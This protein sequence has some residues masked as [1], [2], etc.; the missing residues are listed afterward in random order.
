M[1]R[2]PEITLAG[3][4]RQLSQVQ[5]KHLMRACTLEQI[6]VFMAKGFSAKSDIGLDLHPFFGSR[7]GV[8][9]SGRFP[10]T[11]PGL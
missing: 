9:P 7:S 5:G 8:N 4:E 3:R 1:G 11:L 10:N 2:Y 6:K